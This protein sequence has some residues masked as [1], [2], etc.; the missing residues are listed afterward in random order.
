LN[1][2]RNW[3]KGG[4]GL[5]IVEMAAIDYV[6]AAELPGMIMIGSDETIPG[7]TSLAKTLKE[8]GTAPGI[9]VCHGGGC[10]LGKPSFGPS[11]FPYVNIMG[12][13]QDCE[14]MT[15]AQIGEAIENYGQA[16]L[17]AKKAGFEMVEI[18]MAHGYLP[19]AFYSPKYNLRTD[20][21]GGSP[22]KRMRFPIE[23]L[24]SVKKYVGSDF[25]VSCRI[26]GTEWEE[27]GITLE[28]S[29][30][31]A[32]ALEKAGA[33]AI[34][35]SSA[36]AFTHYKIIIPIYY[37]RG[38]N[39]FLAEAVK[40][41]GIKVPVIC[42]GG[43]TV[44]E[45]AE[46]ILATGKA[47]FVAIGRPLWADPEW[48][49]KAREGRVDEIRPCV[50]QNISCG[51]AAVMKSGVFTCSVNPEFQTRYEGT[52][53]KTPSPKDV[54]VIGAGPGG[55]QAAW[56]AATKGH[57][58][59]L[60]E[61]RDVLGGNLVEDAVPA[62][63]ADKARL[64]SHFRHEMK[65]LG[66]NVKHEEATTDTIQKGKYDAVIVATGSRRSKPKIKGIDKPIAVDFVEALRGRMKGNDI[67]ILATDYEIRCVDVAFYAN[68]LNKKVTILFTQE[69]TTQ[70]ATDMGAAE[71]GMQSQAIMDVLPK[72]PNISIQLGVE[73][74]EITDRGVVVERNGKKETIPADT[75]VYTPEF[76]SND[77]IAN[78][79]EKKGVK[80]AKVG[81]CVEPMRLMCYAIHEGH[82]AA[83]KL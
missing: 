59:T 14:E 37:P 43:I 71:S 32:Q 52:L 76:V 48:P 72:T 25:P 68:E 30:P 6:G 46:E 54:A 27:G 38:N 82:A 10:K 33:D 36:G 49:N 66:V 18:H 39:V 4:V 63:R 23:V 75:V 58:V 60:Y 40:R 57:K 1:Y 16:A 19:D 21:W 45:L 7:L 73:P 28:E 83:K 8:N 70:L 47:D 61:K 81:D 13:K 15:E 41:S 74:V 62:F 44:P 22:E 26:S 79:L 29:I 12:M 24:K 67:V 9:Q 80:V 77:G 55:L 51:G 17:R 31:F 5:V 20:Q 56:V 78:A 65:R 34:N 35:V 50:R 2:Y 42:N 11:K 3:A 69:N 64:L 53:D